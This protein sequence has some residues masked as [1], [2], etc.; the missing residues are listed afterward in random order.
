MT[1]A[2]E[3]PLLDLAVGLA[4][5][6]AARSRPSSHVRVELPIGWATYPRCLA[7]VFDHGVL[8]ITTTDDNLELQVYL[9]DQWIEAAVYD[10]STGYVVYTHRNPMASQARAQA[11]REVEWIGEEMRRVQAL[12]EDTTT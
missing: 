9:P 11:H 6:E 10:D 12:R 5:A 1:D 7:D 8:T 3:T 2:P 4:R